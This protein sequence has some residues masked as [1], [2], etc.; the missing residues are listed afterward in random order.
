MGSCTRMVPWRRL[1]WI[2]IAVSMAARGAVNPAALPILGTIP[3]FY[4]THVRHST[5]YTY[6]LT[7][8]HIRGIHIFVNKPQLP[9]VT[10]RGYGAT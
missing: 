8:I 7:Y 9:I 1:G 5:A 6:I 2:A 10:M 3:V 4:P